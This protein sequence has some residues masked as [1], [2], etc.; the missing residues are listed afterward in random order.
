MHR[1]PPGAA[2]PSGA[3]TATSACET[4]EVDRPLIGTLVFLGVLGLIVLLAWGVQALLVYLFF[5]VVAVVIALGMR[6]G[7][8]WGEDASR[9]RF[10]NRSSS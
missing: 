8:G 2:D 9:G 4:A 5:A 6:I 3:A 1:K 7:G 10:K